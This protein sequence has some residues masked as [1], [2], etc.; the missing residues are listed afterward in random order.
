MTNEAALLKRL[1]VLRSALEG[2]W[3]DWALERAHPTA[4]TGATMCRF[5]SA[6]LAMELDGP[7]RIAGGE[8]GRQDGDEAGFFDGENWHA[9]YWVTDGL[10][11]VDLTANQFGAEPI[12]TTV[13]DLRY[14]ENY[15]R[16]EIED[17]LQHV[18]DSVDQWARRLTA[19]T[20]N[21]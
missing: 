1:T 19:E 16:V 3:A 9:H 20:A 21:A 11:I 18:A 7:W 14:V 15:T 5:T 13:D 10:Q 8:S 2:F 17:A 12:I 6:F 4:A